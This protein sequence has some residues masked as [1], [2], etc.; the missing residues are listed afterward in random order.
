MARTDLNQISE[1]GVIPSLAERV[2]LTRTVL[3]R[4]AELVAKNGVEGDLISFAYGDGVRRPHP[5]VIGAAVRALLDSSG[6]SLENYHAYEDNQD[7]V[8][9]ITADFASR[10]VAPGIAGNV[11]IGFGTTNLFCMYLQRIVGRRQIILVPK[12]YYHE[13]PVWCEQSGVELRCVPTSAADGYKLT[14]DSLRAWLSGRRSEWPRIHGVIIANPTIAGAVYTPDELEALCELLLSHR[15]KLIYDIIWADTEFEDT[16]KNHFAIEENLAQHCVVL[17]GASKSLGLANLHVGW[18]CGPSAVIAE[19]TWYRDMSIGTVPFL[20]Q[21]M[22]AAG[23]AAPRDYVR[24]NSTECQRRAALIQSC[25]GQINAELS[26]SFGGPFDRAMQVEHDPRAGHSILISSPS[27][28]G[29]TIPEGGVIRTSL[30]LANYLLDAAGV[31]LLPAYSMGFEGTE[32]RLSFGTA[33]HHETHGELAA[34][35]Y[36]SATA[37][38]G[39]SG[40]RRSDDLTPT[41][42]FSRG[43]ELIRRALLDRVLPALRAIVEHNVR[44]GGC[45]S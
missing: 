15:F 37:A 10:G 39:D 1:A 8:A 38:L 31:M 42:G 28:V 33:G 14:A 18:I 13:I 35:E 6:R 36:A 12:G 22:A 40:H 19:L 16:G 32:I 4:S 23:L 41:H 30:D 9:A 11:C 43:R 7:L 20:A 26:A 27:L 34:P 3:R 21:A 44:Q 25:I 2:R 45:A 17:G 24:S 5:S 29:M